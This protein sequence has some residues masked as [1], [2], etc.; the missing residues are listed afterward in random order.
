M[1]LCSPLQIVRSNLGNL[2]ISN[3]ICYV[4]MMDNAVVLTK[5]GPITSLLNNMRGY[6][7]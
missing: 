2:S 3:D 7:L 1:L 5:Y 4:Q 6:I